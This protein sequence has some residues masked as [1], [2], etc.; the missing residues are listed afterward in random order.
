MTNLLELEAVLCKR[1]CCSW[2]ATRHLVSFSTCGSALF[3]AVH[4]RF[5]VTA[6]FGSCLITSLVS[7]RLLHRRRYIPSV[8]FAG[9]SRFQ[10]HCC[11]VLYCRSS[12]QNVLLLLLYVT[13]LGSSF[14]QDGVAISATLRT[15]RVQASYLSK[16][17]TRSTRMSYKV[18]VE[19]DDDLKAS[20]DRKASPLD[21]ASVSTKPSYSTVGRN[22]KV[23]NT[24]PDKLEVW[25]F[26][27]RY[28]FTS[29]IK[30]G[31]G[32]T[33]E[34]LNLELEGVRDEKE[35][36]KIVTLLQAPARSKKE[37]SMLHDAV[38]ATVVNRKTGEVHGLNE[39]VRKG[40]KLIIIAD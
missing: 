9:L 37:H 38:Y 29:S 30:V 14:L 8:T 13:H 20:A 36:S 7:A 12:M 18:L 22:F 6:S 2:R 33:P 15:R 21:I 27:A 39:L 23:D 5:A 11:A 19:D 3:A 17:C 34:S 35:P 26:E 25:H 31:A 4:Y 28:A 40:R 10:A 24:T 1:S 32:V 16:S